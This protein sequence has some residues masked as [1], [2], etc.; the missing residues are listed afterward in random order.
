[1]TSPSANTWDWRQVFWRGKECHHVR[2]LWITS[3]D[4]CGW[5]KAIL[6]Y[7]SSHFG[8]MS[9]E[10][11]W[12]TVQAMLDCRY[13]GI[14]FKL[15]PEM[16]TDVQFLCMRMCCWAIAEELIAASERVSTKVY[17][18]GDSLLVQYYSMLHI[19]PLFVLC[20]HFSPLSGSDTNLMWFL[21]NC[22]VLMTLPLVW[23]ISVSYTHLTLPTIYSV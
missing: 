5:T 16:A 14:T 11:K 1:M 19:I 21:D 7:I 18:S 17:N 15:K 2:K 3:C 13:K 4:L 9:K 6:T 8:L 12:V 23:C 10:H 20:L 22:T